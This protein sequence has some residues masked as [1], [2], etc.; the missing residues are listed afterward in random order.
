MIK[1]KLLWVFLFFFLVSNSKVVKAEDFPVNFFSGQLGEGGYLYSYPQYSSRIYIDKEEGS[2][3]IELDSDNYSAGAVGVSPAVDLSKIRYQGAVEFLIK[4]NVGGERSQIALLDSDEMDLQ[5]T[6]VSLS[7]SPFVHITSNWQLVSIPLSAFSDMGTFWDGTK[8]KIA[9]FDWFDVREVRFQIAPKENEE[10][11]IYVK[12]LKIVAQP[13]ETKEVQKI[14]ALYF[15]PHQVIKTDT[16]TNTCYVGV[17]RPLVPKKMEDLQDYELMTGKKP[18]FIVFYVDWSS[19][20][21]LDDCQKLWKAGYLPLITW[22]PWWWS[23]REKIHLNNIINGEWDEYIIKWAKSI[24][25]WG[26][27]LMLRWAHE[28][29]G[30][31]YP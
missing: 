31:W 29:N 25:E 6:E 5:K 17:F 4:G 11:K 13:R 2:L 27:P 28:F 14:K 18:A 26:K 23:D 1:K 15:K 19:N 7:L 9:Q 12:D 22:E 16:K 21:P 8:S 10:F 20:F 24:K 3:V 30:D